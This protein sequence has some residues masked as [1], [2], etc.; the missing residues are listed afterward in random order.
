MKKLGVLLLALNLLSYNVLLSQLMNTE[1]ENWALE[2]E[3][4]GV[5]VYTRNVSEEYLKE[6]KAITTVSANLDEILTF[7][8]EISNA[9]EW[10]YRIKDSKI[11]DRVNK[12]EFYVHLQADAPWPVID[13][14]MVYRFKITQPTAN[15]YKC[16][17]INAPEKIPPQKDHIRIPKMQGF[18][19][20]V[21]LGDNQIQI[22]HQVLSHPGG[23]LPL[24]L[25]NMVVVSGPY[26]TLS[27]LKKRFPST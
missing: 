3:D 27:N 12:E 26:T 23:T 9:P 13:R 21:D 6:Y 22:T 16:V 5:Q 1:V 4:Q 18:W 15:S 19:E 7:I 8:S 10:G 17:M 24:W 2:K 11:I 25:A 14:D 20:L